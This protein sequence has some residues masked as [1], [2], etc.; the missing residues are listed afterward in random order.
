MTIRHSWAQP[1]EP[2][3]FP[4]DFVCD[5]GHPWREDAAHAG[6]RFVHHVNWKFGHSHQWWY[7]CRVC[8]ECSHGANAKKETA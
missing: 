8:G 4:E 1:D 7:E 2:P 6:L 5:I 3:E